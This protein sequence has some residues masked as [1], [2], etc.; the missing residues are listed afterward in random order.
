MSH[1]S[2]PSLDV[3]F[4]GTV[5]NAGMSV[6]WTRCTRELMPSLVSPCSCVGKRKRTSAYSP[7]T[8][9]TAI[10]GLYASPSAF[11]NP[12][13]TVGFT[14]KRTSRYASLSDVPYLRA[15]IDPH[16]TRG[17][18]WQHTSTAPTIWSCRYLWFTSRP[19]VIFP[20]HRCT[21]ERRWRY[22][23][24]QVCRFI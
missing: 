12:I 2:S 18:K 3:D 7:C 8:H 13:G 15:E 10:Y 16:R 4:I 17:S 20:R 21:T 6:H 11:V 24:T 22:D 19:L 1:Y 23:S 14:M 5:V 9:H